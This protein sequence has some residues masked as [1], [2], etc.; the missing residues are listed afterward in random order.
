MPS[1]SVS[2]ALGTNEEG[3]ERR[4]AYEQAAKKEYGEVRGAINQ[5]AKKHLD[6]AADFKKK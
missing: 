1:Y 5:W 2:L 6:K 3:L 4:R